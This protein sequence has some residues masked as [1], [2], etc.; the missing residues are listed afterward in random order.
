MLTMV[1]N[2]EPKERPVFGLLKRIEDD[3]NRKELLLL[4]DYLKV[5]TVGEFTG[6]TKKELQDME[7]SEGALSALEGVLKKE[8]DIEL[9][10]EPAK[11]PAAKPAEDKRGYTVEDKG[12]YILVNGKEIKV[13]NRGRT[14]PKDK[15]FKIYQLHSAGKTDE[16]IQAG[17]GVQPLTINNW[18]YKADV[19]TVQKAA[20]KGGKRKA[21]GAPPPSPLQGIRT[22]NLA[23]Y[24]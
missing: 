12:D 23:N 1:N 14:T 2:M 22:R 4:R 24:L 21:S 8:Y 6:Y 7:V 19:K 16:E 10:T 20:K 15:V 13:S 18:L 17:T 5:E 11:K 9:R 3:D